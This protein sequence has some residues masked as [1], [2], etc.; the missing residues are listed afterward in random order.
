MSTRPLKRCRLA[1]G[2][3]QAEVASEIGVTQPTYQRWESGTTAL[4][5]NKTKRLAKVLS[6]SEDELSGKPKPFD[7]F[8]I[9]DH[10]DDD[11][12]YF[13]EVAIHFSAPGRPM[14]VPIS[15]KE[16]LWIGKQ[17][18][19]NSRFIQIESLDNRTIFVRSEA[20]CDLFLSSEAYDT[21]GP[22]EYD[23]Y[24][25]V[26]PD[27]EFWQI[28]ENIECLD[29]IEDEHEHEHSAIDKILEH[30]SL[31]TDA[32]DEQLSKGEI[33]E[34]QRKEIEDRHKS[35]MERFHTRATSVVW[36]PTGRLPR[37]MYFDE[38]EVLYDTFS[39]LEL[40]LE[41]DENFVYLRGEGY[42]R[43][44]FVNLSQVDYFSIPSHR[45]DEG[46]LIS[47]EGELDTKC[48]S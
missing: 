46:R 24:L 47:L 22:D 9:D 25:C 18:D 29:M 3:T 5:K 36:Q 14:L 2:K 19:G 11:R 31:D 28:V 39:L 40:S 1:V 16:R 7:L 48:L 10:V 13:G 6:C 35:D 37:S 26:Y 34:A 21:F 17:I 15:E 23:E 30:L 42:H 38:D 27:D 43:S 33:S 8:G 12:T 41:D 44:A 4:P 45:F 20:I 32:L